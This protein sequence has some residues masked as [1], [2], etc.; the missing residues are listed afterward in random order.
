MDPK[1]GVHDASR[2]GD[3]VLECSSFT[4][5]GNRSDNQDRLMVL[6]DE[7]KGEYLFAVADGMGGHRSGAEAAQAAIS[8]LESCWA[9]RGVLQNPPD[10]IQATIL[11]CHM[12]VRALA[13]ADEWSP[14]GTTLAVLLVSS[15]G[16]WSGHVG[17]TRVMHYSPAGLQN[18]TRDHSATELKLA[19]GRISEEEAATDPDLNR[20]TQ[21][22]GGRK[23]PE[24]SVK[25]WCPQHG[26]LLCVASDGAWSL[27]SDDDFSV[28]RESHQLGPALDLLMESRL[29]CAP[30]GQDNAT[31]ILLRK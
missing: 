15:E 11:R 6:S 24:A 18:R 14:P 30:A 10:W 23:T 4:A 31:L 17:D 9:E 28:L 26:D 25:S 16:A 1:L 29:S 13:K 5:V 22:L 21:A 8:T 2:I 27:L 3:D 20:V 12:A 7:S 19:A